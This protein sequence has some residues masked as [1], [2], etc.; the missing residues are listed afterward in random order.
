VCLPGREKPK[1]VL[2]MSA[3]LGPTLSA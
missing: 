2:E 1:G 3:Y